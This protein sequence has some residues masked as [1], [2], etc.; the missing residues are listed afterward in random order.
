MEERQNMEERQRILG[1]PIHR[2]GDYLYAV[3]R[4][5]GKMVWISIGDGLQADEKIR[6]YCRKHGVNLEA[7]C[8]LEQT[9]DL[10]TTVQRLETENEALTKRVKELES[11]LALL[12]PRLTVLEQSQ[13]QAPKA[14]ARARARAKKEKPLQSSA[15]VSTANKTEQ[16]KCKGRYKEIEKIA[17]VTNS[18]ICK[19]FKGK[20]SKSTRAKIKAAINEI[21]G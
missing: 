12:E 18:T 4:I 8:K 17:G 14:K 19:Y 11:N 16:E 10:I 21:I 1:F 20:G 7:I 5:K 9:E 13:I 3:K 6:A 15:K 2:K